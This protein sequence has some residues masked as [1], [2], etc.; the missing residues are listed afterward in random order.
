MSNRRGRG[1]VRGGATAYS[2]RLQRAAV[3]TP[4]RRPAPAGFRLAVAAWLAAG[5]AMLAE[6]GHLGT[7]Y[8]EWSGSAVRGGYHVLA[9]ALLGLVAV[10]VWS[11]LS[12]PGV[13]AGVGAAVAATGPALWLAGGLLG[14]SPYAELPVPPAAGLAGIELVLA[15]LLLGAVWRARGLR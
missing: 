14:A 4:R 1:R 6:L 10:A 8:A 7:A 5:L 15:A 12:R 9:G 13:V 3:R 2:V 11:G